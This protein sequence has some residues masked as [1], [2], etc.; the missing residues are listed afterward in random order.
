L[1][2]DGLVNKGNKDAL[3]VD[4]KVFIRGKVSIE[5]DKGAKLI[6]Q[7]VIPF[8]SIPRKLYIRF[9]D[10]EAYE[11]KKEDL[12]KSISVSDGIDG[13]YVVCTKENVMKYLGKSMTV[14]ANDELVDMLKK[15]Y[16][17]SN[18]ALVEGSIAKK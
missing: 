11:S 3:I 13:V 8:D 12:F 16:G 10:M 2:I 9:S 17:E 4:N 14:N 1:F 18:V 15:E 7:E 5:E 6:C